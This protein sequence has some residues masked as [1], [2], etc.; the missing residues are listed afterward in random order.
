MTISLLFGVHAHQP[1][2][3]FPAVIDDAHIRSYGMFLR[4][5]ERYP[6]VPLQRAFVGLAARRAGYERFPTTWRAWRR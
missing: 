3:N 1:V 5:M 4:V 2:G 6:G